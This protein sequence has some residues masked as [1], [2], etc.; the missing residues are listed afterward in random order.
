MSSRSLTSALVLAI[1]L[2]SGVNASGQTRPSAPAATTAAAAKTTPTANMWTPP[3]TPWGDPDL[4]GIFTSDDFMD[5][6]LERPTAFGERLY[7]TEGELAEAAAKLARQAEAA[8]QGTLQ[9]DQRLGYTP[10]DAR[11]GWGERPRRPVRQTSLIVDPPNGKMPPLTPEGRKRQSQIKQSAISPQ[12]P[13]ASWKDF[14]FYIRCISRG[15]AGSIL[16]SSYDNGTQIVQAPGFV[17]I[18]HEK[19]H[20]ARI[21][22]LDQRPHVGNSIRSYLG[23]SRGHWEGNT[24]VV[25]TTNFLDDT[26][27]IGR[28]GSNAVS[29]S[30]ALRLVER[31]TRVGP[32][33]IS[34]ELS[35]DD[36]K[37]FT[38]PWKIAFLITQ[39]SGYELFEY[40]CHETNYSMTNI[41][42]GTR[43]QEKAES[44]KQ[45]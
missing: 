8:R 4:Q 39:E 16:P 43:A 24:L 13:P 14:D 12:T 35:I 9:R 40:T 38:G 26:T 7:F 3:K 17:T 32:D 27:S 23:D 34:Y 33:T 11:V 18:F 1:V 29:T 45:K 5:T 30:D 28:N 41:L 15:L 42:S 20:E 36:P 31:F 2:I 44:A 19:I 21:I 22:P 10:G 25:E 37:I 6:P